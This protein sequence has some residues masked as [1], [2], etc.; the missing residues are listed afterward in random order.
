V[1]RR[2]RPAATVCVAPW[3]PAVRRGAGLFETVGCDAGRAFL[4]DGHLERMRDGAD[5]LGWRLPGLPGE[6]D[7]E[8]LLARERLRGPAALRVLALNEG[9]RVR[10]IAWAESVRVAARLRRDGSRLHPVVM[11]SGPL[12][13]V[14]SSSYL[15]QRWAA[16]VAAAAGADAALLVDGDGAVRETDHANVFVVIGGAVAT[17]PSPARCLPGVMRGWTM[18]TLAAAGIPVAERD[19]TAVEL[20][21]SEGAWL[22]SSLEGIVPVRSVGGAALPRPVAMLAALHAAGVPAPGY[23]RRRR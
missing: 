2:L 15:P 11:A 19:V 10:V 20:A 17:P 22:T 3:S 12:A 6:R 16:A 8:R 23:A 5:A 14:K 7:V 4:L 1:G 18:R 13:A 9:Q 21:A